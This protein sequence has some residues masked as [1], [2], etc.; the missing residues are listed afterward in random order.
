M[1]STG[2]VC[3]M[4]MHGKFIFLKCYSQSHRA[5]LLRKAVAVVQHH[6][7]ITGTCKDYVAEDYKKQLR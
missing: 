1:S 5:N 4:I 7:A 6:D 2:K 3:I